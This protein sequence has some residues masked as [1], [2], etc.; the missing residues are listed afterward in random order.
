[1]QVPQDLMWRKFLKSFWILRWTA[2][3]YN[4]R[5]TEFACGKQACLCLLAV[6]LGPTGQSSR[7]CKEKQSR[8]WDALHD[9]HG[10]IY[11]GSITLWAN[12]ANCKGNKPQL[13]YLSP[14]HMC[15]HACMVWF[16]FH[17]S[18]RLAVVLVVLQIAHAGH[19]LCVSVLSSACTNTKP[20]ATPFFYRTSISN[21]LFIPPMR[22]LFPCLASFSLTYRCLHHCLTSH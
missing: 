17:C 10:S 22:S 7:P 9:T 5:P 6:G 12:D 1:M 21:F 4:D 16:H 2:S 19:N 8:M 3:V 13:F 11:R 15:H 14:H 18:C 20:N